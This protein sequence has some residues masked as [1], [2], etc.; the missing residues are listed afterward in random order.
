MKIFG[1]FG[2]LI[3]NM[4]TQIQ[5]S[6]LRWNHKQTPS[7]ACDNLCQLKKS[8]YV[9]C[10]DHTDIEKCVRDFMIIH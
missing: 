6:P 9:H 3:F 8:A 5:S 2:L 7:E 1:T 10:K 4:M